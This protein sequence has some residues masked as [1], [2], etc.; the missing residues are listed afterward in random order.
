MPLGDISWRPPRLESGRVLLRG[1]EPGDVDDIFAYG[2]DPEVTP[3]MAWDRHR[4]VADARTFL[5]AVVAT[6]YRRRELDYALCLRGAPSPV[7]GG[8]G[9]FWRSAR[10]QVMELGY[11]LHR[12]YWGRGLV[13][14]AARA[15]MRFAFE[16]TPV[17]RIYAPI[18]AP[19]AKSRRAAEKMGMTLD[20][21][22]RS[23][24]AFRGQRWD[25]AIYSILRGEASKLAE[26]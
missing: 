1:Y 14:E 7:I 20:G 3:F 16:T 19:N 25:E 5:D 21:V 4:T 23:A 24:V 10:H 26:P 11:V 17:E 15:L 22:L 8:V 9:L 2:S 18:F 6:S 13:P 12:A